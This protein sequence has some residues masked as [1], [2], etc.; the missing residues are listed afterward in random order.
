M[1]SHVIT[2]I[3]AASVSVVGAAASIITNWINQ[4]TTTVRELTQATLRERQ[5]LYAEFI[6]EASRLAIDALSH[7]LESLETLVTLYGIIGRI[8]LVSGDAVLAEAENLCRR[9]VDL[10]ATPNIA[11]DQVGALLNSSELDPLKPFSSACRAELLSIA[12]PLTARQES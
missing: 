5:T 10:Y 3:V 6:T 12:H 8:R 9:I 4:R 2:G 11:V 7:S 1:D